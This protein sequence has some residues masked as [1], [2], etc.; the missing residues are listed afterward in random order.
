M[1]SNVLMHASSDM[2]GGREEGREGGREGRR[3]NKSILTNLLAVPSTTARMMLLT[4][5][6]VHMIPSSIVMTLLKYL[7][8]T[9]PA[10]QC[11]CTFHCTMCMDQFRHQ[12]SESTCTLLTQHVIPVVPTKLW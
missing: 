9:T 12:R 1:D 7:K 8:H 10:Y 4:Q 3:K 6:M 11:S 5:G 2:E